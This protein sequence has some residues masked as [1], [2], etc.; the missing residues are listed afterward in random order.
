MIVFLRALWARIIMSEM[1]AQD[2][3][4]HLRGSGTPRERAGR[5]W[6]L[7]YSWW[8]S[9]PSAIYWSHPDVRGLGR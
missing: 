6:R 9:R 4:N 7:S 2:I 8:F 1:E 5:L 3:Q